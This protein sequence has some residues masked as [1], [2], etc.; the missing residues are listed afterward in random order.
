MGLSNRIVTRHVCESMSMIL[1]RTDPAVLRKV[2]PDPFEANRPGEV[3]F[4]F[5]DAYFNDTTISA[6][7]DF[8]YPY[9]NSMH[10]VTL[11]VP[12]SY[13]GTPGTVMG[14]V[15]QDRDWS[16]VR[17]PVLGY[18]TELAEVHVTRFPGAMAKFYQPGIGKKVKG[19]LRQGGI[20]LASAWLELEEECPG[21][22]WPEYLTVFAHRQVEDLLDPHTPLVDQVLYEQHDQEEQGTIWRGTPHLKL[23][24][25]MALWPLELVDGFYTSVSFGTAG[26][27]VLKD[28]DKAAHK[29]IQ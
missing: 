13:G 17:G 22:P 18:P 12:C 14:R 8:V 6:R 28:F 7:T 23:G 5:V 26:S 3:L 29:V 19:V 16:Y 10:Q 24:G 20:E 21:F 27:V 11:V 4:C 15:W 25:D 1:C 2:L 9:F